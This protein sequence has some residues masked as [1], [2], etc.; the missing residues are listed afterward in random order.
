MNQTKKVFYKKSS[1]LITLIERLP[2]NWSF[3]IAGAITSFLLAS[4]LFSGWPVG[5][6]PNMSF[7]FIYGGDGLSHSW[8]V[9]R[10]IE[11]WIWEN[12]RSG[13]PFG[14]DFYDY[15]G[16]DSGNLLL[17]KLL[18]AFFSE[19]HQSI[20]I[21][22]L[23]NF[24]LAFISSY[25][26][27]LT[28]KI[29]NQ[30]S[31]VG[32]ILFAFI[33]F[34]FLR[35][36]H[37]FYVSY[38]VVPI[39]FYCAF[40]IFF[41]SENKKILSIEGIIKILLLGVLSCF[42]IY[43]SLFGIIVLAVGGLLG[44]FRNQ[45][46]KPLLISFLAISVITSGLLLNLAPSIIHRVKNGVN[47]EVAVRPVGESE[48]YAFKLAQL[49]L[50]RPA[51][52]ITK[53]ANITE[54]Y[55]KTTPLINENQTSSLGF[56]ACLGFIIGGFILASNS[57]GR[58]Q[59]PR[60]SFLAFLTLILFLCGTIGGLGVLFAMF[61][62]PSIRGWNRIS[63]FLA[64]SCLSVFFLFLQSYIAKNFSIKKQNIL[65]SCSAI[66]ILIIGLFDQVV[67]I[68]KSLRYQTRSKFQKDKKF[69]ENIENNMTPHSPIYQLPY[70]Q[71]PEGGLFNN[72]DQYDLCAGFIHSKTLRW[73]YGGMKGRQGD[74]FYRSLSNE[75]IS[76]Q[77][78]VL[79]KLGF[80]GIYVDRRGF[81]DNATNLEKELASHLDGALKL[82]N[83]D[84]SAFFIS[85]PNSESLDYNN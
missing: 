72:L 80:K 67:P 60:I 79:K 26:V 27:L 52:G 31:F 40:K 17:L 49:V 25:I 45:N 22:I 36:G 73:S 10:A 61:I 58:P 76:E 28:F 85:I 70:H 42:G 46:F 3:C 13:Y 54:N 59:E 12:S 44:A 43:Y 68:S 41:S 4:I 56:F 64:F 9:K 69:I 11:G 77:L 51:H 65:L 2:K 33:P 55:N 21:F 47:S 1:K 37:L 39:Y 30:I 57:V 38:F 34:Y 66:G 24:S 48:T 14:S 23:L 83:T 82:E 5:I 62:T 78:P 6:R 71:F 18:G 63:P 81:A 16:S 20:N 53:L 75:P 7:P 19:Y 8:I 84:K 32:S 35:L 50:P 15:P 74:L 29:N